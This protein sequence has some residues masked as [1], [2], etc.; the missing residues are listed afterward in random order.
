MAHP[1]RGFECVKMVNKSLLQS[2]LYGA[3]RKIAAQ[4]M[5]VTGFTGLW[6]GNALIAQR[7]LRKLKVRPGRMLRVRPGG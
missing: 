5:S 7:R 6:A 4:K 3:Q 2:G 1:D